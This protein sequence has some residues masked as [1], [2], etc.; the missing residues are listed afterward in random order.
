MDLSKPM[1]DAEQIE[2]IDYVIDQEFP[3]LQPKLFVQIYNEDKLGGMIRNLEI[4]L[5]DKFSHFKGYKN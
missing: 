3:E 4:W 2:Y 5:N 1:V